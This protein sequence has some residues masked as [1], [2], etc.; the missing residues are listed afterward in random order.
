MEYSIGI[1]K[2]LLLF[3]LCIASWSRVEAKNKATVTSFNADV[4]GN[5]VVDSWNYDLAN[6][7]IASTIK[8]KKNCPGII[9]V[10]I[11]IYQGENM[12]NTLNKKFEKPMK[13]FAD[14]NICGSLD[15]PEPDDDS[16]SIAEG[17]QSAKDC[18]ISSWF[19]D[20]NP[21]DYRIECDFKQEDNMLTSLKMD[22][23]VE[24]E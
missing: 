5:D 3:V 23:T 9:E 13:D 8:V 4:P 7:L 11:R 1:T 10:D 19:S 2:F 6:N 15:Y 21:G 16:C 22:V 20:M 12:V 24:S 18:D 14:Y 17:E